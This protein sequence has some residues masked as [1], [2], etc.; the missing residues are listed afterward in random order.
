[1]GAASREKLC[2]L[3]MQLRLPGFSCRTKMQEDKIARV[4]RVTVLFLQLLKCDTTLSKVAV[5]D[6]SSL[7][8]VQVR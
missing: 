2:Q 7:Q 4:R 6:P 1:M 5:N 8:C 3:S